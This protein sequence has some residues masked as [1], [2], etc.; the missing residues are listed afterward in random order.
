M[1]TE[2]VSLPSGFL[3]RPARDEDA[4]AVAAFANENTEAVIGARIV[5]AQQLLRRWTAPAVDRE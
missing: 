3:L 1:Q 5:S 2:L 4:P